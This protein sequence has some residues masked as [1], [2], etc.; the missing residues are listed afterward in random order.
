MDPQEA[1]LSRKKGWGRGAASGRG[2]WVG[3]CSAGHSRD[4]R[5]DQASP[6]PGIQSAAVP[7]EL[8]V[9]IED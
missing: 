7:G 9:Q 1:E 3:Q 5:R 4:D 6:S 2:W 8:K